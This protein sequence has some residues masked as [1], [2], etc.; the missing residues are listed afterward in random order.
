MGAF[1][2]IEGDVVIRD[3]SGNAVGVILD[4]AIYRLQT[5]TKVASWIGSTAPTVGQKAMASSLP[6]TIASDQSAISMTIVPANAFTGLAVGIVILGG[7]TAGTIQSVRATTYT[8]QTANAQRSFAS[9][10]ASDAAAG[11]GAR[12]VE[13]TYYTSAMVGPLTE[14]VTLNGTTAV[15]TVATNICFIEKMKVVSV[16]ST[17]RNVGT[18]TLYVNNSGGGGTIG[19][20]GI[21][22]VVSAQGDNR[23]FWG[24]HYIQAGKTAS[25]ATLVASAVVAGNTAT[26]SFILRSQD[27]T[28]A[29]SPDVQITEFLSMSTTIVRALGIPIKVAGPA[30]ITAFGVPTNNNATLNASFDFSEV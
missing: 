23:T 9:S 21:G 13:I 27:P 18:I 24:H 22:N 4:G 12:Q 15:A 29:N 5:D 8:E 20:I 10:S 26:C 25:L 3:S 11:V 14:T 6:V 2:V 7:S 16:G 17:T 30:R 1:S 19:T 28:V